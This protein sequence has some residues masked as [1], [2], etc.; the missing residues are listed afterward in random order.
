MGFLIVSGVSAD[1]LL[2]TVI[3]VN[4]GDTITLQN[5]S[6][7]KKIRLAGIDAP[8]INQPYGAESHSALREAVIDK[9]VLIETIETDKYGQVV[10]KVILDGQDINLKQV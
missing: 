3:V 6:G 5:E 2:G 7:Q 4:D 9:S 1:V 8:E 10:G